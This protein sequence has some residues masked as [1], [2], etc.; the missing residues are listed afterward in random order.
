MRYL[1]PPDPHTCPKCNGEGQFGT[2][3][4]ACDNCPFDNRNCKECRESGDHCL[5]EFEICDTCN[6]AGEVDGITWESILKE[7]LEDFKA[8]IFRDQLKDYQCELTF[9][10]SA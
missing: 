2:L 8:D 10:K 1:Q 3:T 9:N 6:G 4:L 7:D 5:E